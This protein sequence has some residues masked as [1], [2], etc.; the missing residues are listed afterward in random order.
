VTAVDENASEGALQEQIKR[1]ER[2]MLEAKAAYSLK[3]N[4]VETVLMTDPTLNAVHA[5][6]NA[7]VA[8][9]YCLPL[10]ADSTCLAADL[11]RQEIV[12]LFAAP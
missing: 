7:S 4:V 9:R 11:S 10:K 2:E 3:T 6:T 12:A 5:G 8:D 1:A